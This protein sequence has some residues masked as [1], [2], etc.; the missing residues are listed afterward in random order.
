MELLDIHRRVHHSGL[1]NHIGCRIPLPTPLNME[2][3]QNLLPNYHNT[4][5][6]DYLE[7]GW[8]IWNMA[9]QLARLLSLNPKSTHRIIERRM[10]MLITWMNTLLEK[11]R[12]ELR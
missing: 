7:Y 10:Y 5:V 2:I 9:G 1:P 12:L 3:Y 4:I 11:Y 6:L 8:I